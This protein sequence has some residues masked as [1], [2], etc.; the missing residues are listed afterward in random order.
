MN[1]SELYNPQKITCIALKKGTYVE[2]CDNQAFQEYPK[3]VELWQDMG[4]GCILRVQRWFK[5]SVTHV[6]YGTSNTWE[7][8][9]QYI[10]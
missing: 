1:L 8:W 3:S 7:Q 5:K 2:P 9:R 10:Y 4:N 6:T